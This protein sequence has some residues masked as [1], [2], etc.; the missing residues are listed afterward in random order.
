MG[1]AMKRQEQRAPRPRT[2]PV[3]PAAK[4]IKTDAEAV[5]FMKSI[6]NQP[7][8]REICGG[9][10]RQAVLQWRRVPVQYCAALEKEFGIPRWIMRPDIYL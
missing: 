3:S 2:R 5:I 10:T 1:S 8:V 7:R 9:I 4:R 6:K